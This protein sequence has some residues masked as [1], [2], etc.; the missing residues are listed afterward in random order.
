MESEFIFI[1]KTTDIHKDKV[2]KDR[3]E[4]V[5]LSQR[6]VWLIFLYPQNDRE[7]PPI[8]RDDL[9]QRGYEQACPVQVYSLPLDLNVFQSPKRI[10][11][12]PS[13]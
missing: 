5:R 13:D 8:V 9:N 1:K 11:D 2:L 10:Q 6:W 7:L 4:Y 3:R 12:Y